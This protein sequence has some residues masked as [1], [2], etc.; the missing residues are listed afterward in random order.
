MITRLWPIIRKAWKAAGIEDWETR[1]VWGEKAPRVLAKG[2]WEKAIALDANYTP[3]ILNLGI[4][5]DLYLG[6]SKQALLLY[7]RY[8][9]LT[10]SGDTTVAK[11]VADLKNRK[12]K[13]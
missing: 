10:P 8:L 9:S 4:L 5:Q 1:E 13:A 12:E 6:D 3:A 11:W 7:E 2:F